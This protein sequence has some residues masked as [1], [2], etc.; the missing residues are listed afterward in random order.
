MIVRNLIGYQT[1]VC[2]FLGLCEQ[3]LHIEVILNLKKGIK[4]MRWEERW[5]KYLIT[6]GGADEKS[7]IY[8]LYRYDSVDVV[9]GKCIDLH[10]ACSSEVTENAPSAMKFFKDGSLTYKQISATQ[11]K[12]LL[13]YARKRS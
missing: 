10:Y 8:L 9:L 1:N 13:A 7:S 2:A 12:K 5:P 11:A 3:V 6:D 4:N